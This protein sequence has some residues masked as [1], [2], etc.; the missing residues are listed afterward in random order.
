MLIPELQEIIKPFAQIVILHQN[1]IKFWPR[2]ILLCENKSNR[3]ERAGEDLKTDYGSFDLL[4]T[5]K[6]V[7]WRS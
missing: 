4:E 2:D 3:I 7:S 5:L 6:I 1:M